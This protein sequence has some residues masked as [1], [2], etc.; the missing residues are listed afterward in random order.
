MSSFRDFDVEAAALRA[1]DPS[2]RSIWGFGSAFEASR[3][4]RMDSDI[5]LIDIAG[6]PDGFARLAREHGEPLQAGHLKPGR[7]ASRPG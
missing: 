3:P 5:D 7:E 2:I 4:F 6:C 1:K